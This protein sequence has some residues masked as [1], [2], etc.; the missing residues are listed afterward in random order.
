MACK[1]D[2]FP[3]KA[4]AA[5]MTFLTATQQKKSKKVAHLVSAVSRDYS[6]HTEI[7]FT[8]LTG[9]FISTYSLPAGKEQYERCWYTGPMWQSPF[10][11]TSEGI[12][13]IEIW[14][15]K[16]TVWEQYSEKRENKPDGKDLRYYVEELGFPSGSVVKNP[17]VNTGDAS[18]IYG[19]RR[20]PGE[21]NNNPLRYSCLGNPIDR[22]A[23]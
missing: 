10:T 19:S 13:H 4:R 18:S 6:F 15:G 22:R 20:S 17:S 7:E 2:S 5:Q 16:S 21:G 23:W 9:C 3:L 11:H 8:V 1:V 14:R 12:M